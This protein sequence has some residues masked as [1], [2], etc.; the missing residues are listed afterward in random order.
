[1]RQGGNGTLR[2]CVGTS[3]L[4]R[5][6]RRH[7]VPICLCRKDLASGASRRQAC[8]RGHDCGTNWHDFEQIPASV[9]WCTMPRLAPGCGNPGRCRDRPC[10]R[11]DPQSAGSETRAE[12]GGLPP[13]TL[14]RRAATGIWPPPRAWFVRLQTVSLQYALRSGIR[15]RNFF[16]LSTDIHAA[17][18]LAIRNELS[19]CALW[20][21]FGARCGATAGRF[22]ARWETGHPHSG[23]PE[24]GLLPE[25]PG[26]FGRAVT[27]SPL[28]DQFPPV[29]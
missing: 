14:I 27:G 16:G 23:N 4:D 19:G 10:H 17:S 22:T 9:H 18:R 2:G 15:R 25:L 20:N 3:S 21:V 11:A 1:M 12:Q 7:V 13:A 26:A 8:S 5:P 24:S 29:A 6:G 28:V